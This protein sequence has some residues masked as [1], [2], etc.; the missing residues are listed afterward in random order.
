MNRPRSVSQ[1]GFLPHPSL[2]VTAVLKAKF[3]FRWLGKGFDV[4][5]LSDS[6]SPSLLAS[7]SLNK[8]CKQAIFVVVVLAEGSLL[9]EH[10]LSAQRGFKKFVNPGRQNL[11][12]SKSCS[13]FPLR[14]HEFSFGHDNISLKLFFVMTG[15]TWSHC[16]WRT[17]CRMANPVSYST[18]EK[19]RFRT[20]YS[21]I[22]EL[23][24]STQGRTGVQSGGFVES[25]PT[26]WNVNV[27]SERNSSLHIFL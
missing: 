4:S 17:K 23:F 10:K 16:S 20:L 25:A 8:P 7:W 11:E 21:R 14:K 9:P 18:Q 19:I 3:L 1:T 6:F 27:C 5:S 13:V 22:T 15:S 24:L 26:W 12:F 2:E